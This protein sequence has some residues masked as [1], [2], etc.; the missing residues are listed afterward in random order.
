MSSSLAHRLTER[1]SITVDGQEW[2]ILFTHD[3]LLDI[4]Q[5]SGLSILSGE[6]SMGRPTAKALRA[7]LQVVLRH[8]GFACVPAV[9]GKLLGS[10][11][12]VEIRN[13]LNRAW[14][15]AMP[16]NESDE[17]SGDAGHIK[18]WMEGWAIAR[19]D[20]GLTSDEWLAMTP[21]MLQALAHQHLEEI[22][23]REFM[24]SQLTAVAANFGGRAPREPFKEDQF[25]LHPWPAKAKQ[26]KT[27]DG[28]FIMNQFASARGTR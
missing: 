1:V 5:E 4:E 27:V 24:Q 21:R 7:I 18:D 8:A 13:L 26:K 10:I 15:A 3:V 11:R 2:P 22:R 25:M 17:G 16:I 28:V 23:Q 14:C 19:H 9:A 12:C 6:L 20:L